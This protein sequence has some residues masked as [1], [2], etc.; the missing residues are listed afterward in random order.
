LQQVLGQMQNEKILAFPSTSATETVNSISRWDE[1]QE[2]MMLGLR[3]TREGVA[4][5][6]FR[7]RFGVGMKAYFKREIDRLVDEE[8]VKWDGDHVN[9]HLRLTQKGI[10]LGNRVFREF[11]GNPEVKLP[12]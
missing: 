9:R 5:A 11:V 6:R 4:E 8:L 10:L 2:T 1:I 3:M 7:S 12:V